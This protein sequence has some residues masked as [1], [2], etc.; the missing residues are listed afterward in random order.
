MAAPR[1]AD[2]L[3]ARLCG[4]DC[5]VPVRVDDVLHLVDR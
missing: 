1:E 4:S 5:W 2:A 3:P